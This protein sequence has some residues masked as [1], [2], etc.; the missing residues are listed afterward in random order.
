MHRRQFLTLAAAVP[1]I[2]IG[3]RAAIAAPSADLWDHWS[4]HDPRSVKSVD[5]A[6]WDRF[7]MRYVMP[8]RD[9]IHR[10]AYGA[11][12]QADRDAL[13]AYLSDMAM[14]SSSSCLSVFTI[15]FCDAA[16]MHCVAVSPV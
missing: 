13:K 14:V 11:V 9:G 7:L 4:A 10:V 16:K 8:S 12:R 5:H 6:R 3:T 15:R 2:G 1:L